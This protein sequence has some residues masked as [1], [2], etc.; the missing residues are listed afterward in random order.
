MIG[1]NTV[2]YLLSPPIG[3]THQVPNHSHT[4]Q[5]QQHQTVVKQREALHCLLDVES[6]EMLQQAKVTTENPPVTVTTRDLM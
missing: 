6:D 3:W 5:Q 1:R 2:C 4:A